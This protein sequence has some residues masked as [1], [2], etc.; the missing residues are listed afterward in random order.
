ML[1]KK[2]CSLFV[3]TAPAAPVSGRHK[4]KARYG[5]AH[6]ASLTRPE[7]PPQPPAPCPARPSVSFVEQRARLGLTGTPIHGMTPEQ[8]MVVKQALRAD[9]ELVE[10]D[11]IHRAAREGIVHSSARTLAEAGAGHNYE[12]RRALFVDS[13][14]RAMPAVA[15]DLV[16]HA[17]DKEFDVVYVEWTRER[18]QLELIYSNAMTPT[19]Y[20][21]FC[22]RLL[23]KYGWNTEVTRASGDQGADVI[24]TKQGIRAVIQVKKYSA[25][26]G[27]DAVQQ[28]YAAQTHYGATVAA[29]VSTAGFTGSARELARST[30]VHLLHHD[31]LASL[32]TRSAEVS[33]VTAAALP[34]PALWNKPKARTTAKARGKKA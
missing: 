9:K 21:H 4:E 3:R 22:G 17:V 13:M 33:N 15:R 16:K 10:R 12:R 11:C 30:R 20:E 18:E 32:P 1:I 5:S 19:E 26:V 31:E 14:C 25:P 7:T 2:L 28:I 24:A 27:N 23:S 34:R 8:C 29:V 6:D